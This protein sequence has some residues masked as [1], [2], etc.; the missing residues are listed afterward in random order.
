MQSYD[1]LMATTEDSSQRQPMISPI[2]TDYQQMFDYSAS[3][4]FPTNSGFIDQSRHQKKQPPKTQLDLYKT[5]LC[6]LMQEGK[7]N[8]GDNC[9]FAHAESEIRNKPNLSKTKLC[10]DHLK[11]K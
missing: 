5:R 9:R 7:C 2:I 10:E 1:H 3:F 8:S 11:G 6:P 4:M